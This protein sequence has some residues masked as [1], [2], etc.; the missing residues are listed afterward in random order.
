MEKDMFVRPAPL[1]AD[2]HGSL[3][4]L[5]R[6][7]ELAYL[8]TAFQRAREGKGSVVAIDG[9]PGIG[10]TQ[11][12]V[13][14]RQI[15]RNRGLR[16][17]AATG[18]E[19]E[20]QFGFGV[21]LQLLE[22]RV[23]RASAEER[24]RLFAGAAQLAAPVLAREHGDGPPDEGDDFSVLHGLYWLCANLAS[25]QPLVMIVDDAHHADGP[26]LRFALYLAQRFHE[27]PVCLVLAG[28]LRSSKP[29][30]GHLAEL[31]AHPIVHTLRLEPLSPE[32]VATQL[33]R[34]LFPKAS[35][36]FCLACFGATGGNPFLLRELA[37]DLAAEG[38]GGSGDA[39]QVLE[40][41]PDSVARAVLLRLHGIGPGAIELAQAVA[42]LGHGA[43]LRHAA[44][45]AELEPAQAAGLADQIMG[46][47]VFARAGLLSF[48][49]PIVRR[50]V[51]VAMPPAERAAAHLRVAGMLA[52]D[53]ASLQRVAT[54]L[55]HASRTG[56]EWVADVLAD[57]AAASVDSGAPESA[58]CYLRRALEE[59]PVPSRRPELVLQLG[60]AEALLAAPEAVPRLREALQ[61]VHEP[62]ERGGA[63]LALGRILCAEGRYAEAAEELRRGIEDVDGAD[64]E[65]HLQLQAAYAPAARLGLSPERMEWDALPEP[66]L[67]N[68]SP[69]TPAA[70]VALA[71]LALTRALEGQPVGR[72][73]ELARRALGRDTLLMLETSDGLG[74]YLATMALT[75][76]EDYQAAELALTAAIE[77]AQ[78]RGSALGYATACGFRALTFVGRGRLSDAEADAESALAAV[79]PV[80]GVAFPVVHAVLAE[81]LMERGQLDKA[82]QRLG[83]T[84]RPEGSGVVELI[85]LATEGHLRWRR[86]DASGALDAFERCGAGLAEA[87][88]RNPTVLSWRSDAALALVE[89]GDQGRAAR[90]VEEELELAHAFGAPGA[91]GSA[92]YA[93]ARTATAGRRERLLLAAHEALE[94]SDKAL[95]R[96]RVLVELGATLRRA[97]SRRA[98]R[99]PLRQGLDLAERCGATSLAQRAREEVTAAGSRPR[100]T[101][102]TGAEA[103]TTRERQVVELAAAGMSNREIAGSLYVTL[104]TVEWHLRHAFDKLGVSSRRE[105]AAVMTALKE[106]ALTEPGGPA[107]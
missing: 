15:A 4:L 21:T 68:E 27:L 89:L 51:E 77:D 25:E 72:V 33:R 53:G 29:S 83:R 71:D 11:L 17:L 93:A 35:D 39:A 42:V 73:R 43:E 95:A 86:G 48:V 97:G 81:V 47:D 100:R 23:A 69:D 106:T 101:A 99:D 65:L 50:A 28:N 85:R 75:L 10:K 40:S 96:A 60:H 105:L 102:L 80:Y 5:E 107:S 16:V 66:R 64:A 19:I 104:K 49:H 76:C 46:A 103:L 7:V 55:L 14:A 34:S 20:S 79:S 52:E 38:E 13:E 78:A 61:L 56:S 82:E 74:Y 70:R 98:A 3:P 1:S 32:G 24:G 58:V 84:S 8:S 91:I 12:L 67:S 63:A 37:A 44:H 30:A 2:D 88:I 59:P 36:S 94:R 22:A 90:L 87:N 57:A 9:P 41:A 31:L 92:L 6:D 54:H 26:S 18:H 62:V 45:I